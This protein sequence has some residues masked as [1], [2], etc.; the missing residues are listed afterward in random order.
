MR[1]A[2][3]SVAGA[4]RASHWHRQRRGVRLEPV[5][6]E[7]SISALQAGAAPYPGVETEMARSSSS[8]LL[9]IGFRGDRC[10]ASA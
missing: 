9:A 8:G 1:A 5:R 6:G 10:D 3:A 4:W 2:P 7:E